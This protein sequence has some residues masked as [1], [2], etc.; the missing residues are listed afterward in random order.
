MGQS[1][2][3]SK[4]V[5]EDKI[6]SLYTFGMGVAAA[7]STL[8]YLKGQIV[9]VHSENDHNKVTIN[10]TIPFNTGKR[11]VSSSLI[12]ISQTSTQE[13]PLTT[14]WKPGQPI[15][16]SSSM[17]NN[18]SSSDVQQTSSCE[19]VPCD[20]FSISNVS[21]RNQ[22]LRSNFTIQDIVLESSSDEETFNFSEIQE[23]KTENTISNTQISQDSEPHIKKCILIFTKNP[24]LKQE[25]LSHLD[26]IVKIADSIDSGLRVFNSFFDYSARFSAIL[27]DFNEEDSLYIQDYI[28][29]TERLCFYQTPIYYSVK[30]LYKELM[31]SL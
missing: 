17:I 31:I 25:L 1:F 28:K 24:T 23:E 19:I 16:H 6:K 4:E 21:S 7:N 5:V 11:K 15:A 12:H 27:V 9:K 2:F 13:T 18:L 14:R 10:L 22:T 26:L 8:L 30:D 20:F 29:D 3:W